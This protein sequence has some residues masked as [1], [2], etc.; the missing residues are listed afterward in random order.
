[1]KVV[2]SIATVAMLVDDVLH[3]VGVTTGHSSEEIPGDRLASTLEVQQRDAFP[4]SGHD[5]IHVYQHSAH[6][7]ILLQHGREDGAVSAGDVHG[8]ADS[9][10]VLDTYQFL[11]KFRR[12]LV[13]RHPESDVI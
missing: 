11:T 8:R 4:R 5:V 10:E 6:V 12:I 13:L 1:M 3:H 7:W 2:R 9:A